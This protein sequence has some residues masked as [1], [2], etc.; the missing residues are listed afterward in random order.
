[1][2]VFFDLAEFEYEGP[3]LV[4]ASDPKVLLARAELLK[5]FRQDRRRVFYMKQ[6]EVLFEKTY[7]HWVTNRAL[8]SLIDDGEIHTEAASLSTGA[9]INLLWYKSFRH[10]KRTSARL[11]ELVNGYR[12]LGS[13]ICG[14]RAASHSC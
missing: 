7:F 12:K 10:Y 2:S 8:H 1:V 11:R 9:P 3:D 14:R 6:V 13:T 4:V 5:F